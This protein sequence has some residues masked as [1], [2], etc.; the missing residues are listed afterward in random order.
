MMRSSF[1]FLLRTLAATALVL[2]A[3]AGRAADAPFIYQGRLVLPDGPAT[4]VYDFVFSLHDD[5]TTGNQVSA[6]ISAEGLAVKEGLF[7]AALDFGTEALDGSARWLEIAVREGASTGSFT[8]LSP[9]T[10][11]GRAP[12]AIHALKADRA[13]T[14]VFAL[15]SG[16]A[17]HALHADHA[18]SA[19]S[20]AHADHATTA[21]FA[22]NTAALGG[23]PA[24]AYVASG[25]THTGTD[26]ED[27]TIDAADL[28]SNPA[29]LARVTGGAAHAT[30]D[31]RI[32]LGTTSPT[33]TLD[34]RGSVAVERSLILKDP[35]LGMVSYDH[36]TS[37]LI[38]GRTW[39]GVDQEMT[40]FAISPPLPEGG[41][42]FTAGVSGDLY[43]IEVLRGNGGYPAQVFL[44]EGESIEG[45][46]LASG[47]LPAAS[48]IPD[49]QT[50]EISPPVRVS[51]GK[52]YTIHLMGAPWLQW[53]HSPGTVDS[54]PG[55]KGFYVGPT[56][57]Y[58]FRT[59]VRG[60]RP[61]ITI[62]QNG[63]VTIHGDLTVHGQA[64]RPGG[65]TWTTLSDSQAKTDIAPISGALDKILQLRGV[66][67]QWKDPAAV[68]ARNNAPLMGLVADEVE[69]VLPEWV[70]QGPDGLR[71]L[72]T[73][74]F[75]ALAVEALREVWLRQNG[76]QERLRGELRKLEEENRQLEELNE[77]LRTRLDRLMELEERLSR[78]E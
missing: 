19:P 9:R 62:A 47:T 4:G 26:I 1:C 6:S 71:R 8:T 32:G 74:G 29:S 60:V 55:G 75:P 12:Q 14:A 59:Y 30:V 41:Q 49:W 50:F 38:I 54:Y 7:Q 73:T 66:T 5:P 61:Q 72:H 18:A 20:A 40:E 58:A 46:V 65:G 78:L 45:T 15:E 2:P 25:H 44:R 68:G 51:A 16:T 56:Q 77:S 37:S 70:S 57:D 17:P 43:R 76:E 48:A 24:S 36:E 31:G 63:D 22:L 53:F 11:L 69:K 34:V 52:K 67:Y 33:Q 3:A 10:P 13:T 27:E 42:S 23:L 21:A 35:E 64:S 39:S 28:T